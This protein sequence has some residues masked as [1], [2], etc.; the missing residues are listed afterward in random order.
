[1]H[2]SPTS[3]LGYLSFKPTY[4]WLKSV[5]VTH[6][7]VWQLILTDQKGSVCGCMVGWLYCTSHRQRGHLETA[8]PFTVPCE[9]HETL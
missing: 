5:K 6:I 3:K 9:G 4:S 8:L 2:L 7:F 1:M